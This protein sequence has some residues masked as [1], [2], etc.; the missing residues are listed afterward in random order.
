MV[1][2]RL[3]ALDTEAPGALLGLAAVVLGADA[4]PSA[5][6]PVW[7][8][9]SPDLV[10]ALCPWLSAAP[11]AA[12]SA[13]V[14]TRRDMCSEEHC[15]LFRENSLK[16]FLKLFLS[17][18]WLECGYSFKYLLWGKFPTISGSHL[19]RAL[20]CKPFPVQF[21]ITF[22]TPLKVRS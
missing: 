11:S 5:V 19:L 13:A 18:E 20:R 1:K 16:T 14:S 12:P 9:L 17:Q 21:K 10:P 15:F 6:G 22:E 4:S 8:R 3:W 2:C 7:P